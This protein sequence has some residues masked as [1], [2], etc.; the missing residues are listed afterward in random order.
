MHSH[1]SE[2]NSIMVLNLRLICVLDYK[3]KTPAVRSCHS[4]HPQLLIPHLL[5][6]LPRKA[7][8]I[9]DGPDDCCRP[10]PLFAP[11]DVYP[12]CFLEKFAHIDDESETNRKELQMPYRWG[13]RWSWL[14]ASCQP[15]PWLHTRGNGDRRALRPLTTC[16]K[17][18][19]I[20]VVR[21]C[22]DSTYTAP[23]HPH[24]PSQLVAVVGSVPMP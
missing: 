5:Q 21:A 17:Y 19:D 23:V 4:L 15:K 24:Q 12:A 11:F 3:S 1:Q 10:S 22:E 16:S 7:P 13:P 18:D 6:S 9:F 2:R 14:L 20:W 8:M